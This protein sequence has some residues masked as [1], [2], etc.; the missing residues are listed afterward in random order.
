M[1]KFFNKEV[2]YAQRSS[3]WSSVRK[4]HL[5]KNNSC[6]ACGRKN[7]LEVHHIVPVHIAPDKELDP[8]NLVTLCA[9]PCHLVFG[10]FMNYRNYNPY[11]LEYCQY[12]R[13]RMQKIHL[14]TA[15]CV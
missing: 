14:D 15:G 9:D 1:F 13:S 11:V 12:Y 8:D 4:Y 3:K 6:L 7:K 10:H 2:R 5:E